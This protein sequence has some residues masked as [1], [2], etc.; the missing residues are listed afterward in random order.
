MNAEEVLELSRDKK[1]RGKIHDANIIYHDENPVCGDTITV[2]VKMKN[3]KVVKSSYECAG[4]VI[5]QAAAAVIA[6]HVQG[7]T[8]KQASTITTDDVKRLLG[9]SLGP[10]RTKCSMLSAVAIKKGILQ[11][12]KVNNGKSVGGEE[13]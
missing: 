12:Q 1:Y 5:S 10:V 11:Y 8:L 4:C 7:K 2:Y 9:I 3:G 6:E 13:K